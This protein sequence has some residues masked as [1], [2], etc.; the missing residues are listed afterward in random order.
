MKRDL[1]DDKNRERREVTRTRITRGAK[2]LL[3]H[4]SS[5]MHCTVQ[6][7]TSSGACI[8]V[9]NTYGMP[10]WFELTFEQGRTRRGCRVIWR[11]SDLLGVTFEQQSAIA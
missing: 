10:D 4:R 1:D 11:T 8:K 2:I 3:P 7:I 9:A 6:N 5:A